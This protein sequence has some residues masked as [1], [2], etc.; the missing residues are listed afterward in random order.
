MGEAWTRRGCVNVTAKRFA[1]Y[2]NRILVFTG[3]K[4]C[5]Y[6]SPLYSGDLILNETVLC[7]HNRADLVSDSRIL[8]LHL[9]VICFVR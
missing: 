9:P 3:F 4:Q 1:G 7:S 5:P 8:E 2:M 6:V